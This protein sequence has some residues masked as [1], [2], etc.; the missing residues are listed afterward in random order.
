MWDV[1]R[2]T[3]MGWFVFVV[4]MATCCVVVPIVLL[5][6]CPAVLEAGGRIQRY[7]IVAGFLIIGGAGF[8][9]SGWLLEKIGIVVQ[10][11]RR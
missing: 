10:R 11:P 1:E 2:F 6:V 7:A 8:Y 4:N 5:N 3:L 9:T